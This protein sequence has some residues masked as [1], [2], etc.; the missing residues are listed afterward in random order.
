[1]L[2]DIYLNL[3]CLRIVH[4]A[5]GG[6]TNICTSENTLLKCT[7]PTFLVVAHSGPVVEHSSG[8]WKVVGSVP[9]KGIPNTLKMVLRASLVSIQH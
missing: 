5:C 1:M 6:T 9:G 4:V 7:V 8:V 2:F 3:G